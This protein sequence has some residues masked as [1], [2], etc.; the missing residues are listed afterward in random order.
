MRKLIYALHEILN[1]IKG[2]ETGYSGSVDNKMIIDYDGDRY[3]ITIEKIE[4]KSKDILDD[5]KIFLR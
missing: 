5:I 4:S 2:F 1:K 3:I